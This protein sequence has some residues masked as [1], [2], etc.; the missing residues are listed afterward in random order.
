MRILI[1]TL[2]LA[3]IATALPKP[4]PVAA[5][6]PQDKP[7]PSPIGPH[8]IVKP[9]YT[10]QPCDSVVGCWPLRVCFNFR[11]CCE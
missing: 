11:C 8:P 10:A 9:T 1:T 3:T 6:E 5:P 2:C 4:D 7:T